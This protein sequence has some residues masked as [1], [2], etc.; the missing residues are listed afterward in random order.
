MRYSGNINNSVKNSSVK[1]MQH[2]EK[3]LLWEELGEYANKEHDKRKFA[4][5]VL[6]Q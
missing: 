6:L 3:F 4:M 2:E 5:L 1:K